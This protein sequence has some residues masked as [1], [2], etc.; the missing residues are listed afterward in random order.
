MMREARDARHARHARHACLGDRNERGSNITARPDSEHTNGGQAS[1]LVR[2]RPQ[3]L[4]WARG[5]TFRIHESS[6]SGTA[7]SW[8]RPILAALSHI[9][10]LVA[11]LGKGVFGKSG[12]PSYKRRSLLS[13][14]RLEVRGRTGQP[15][16]VALQ[17][18]YLMS[19]LGY[20]KTGLESGSKPLMWH[21]AMSPSWISTAPGVPVEI[22]SPGKRVI[23][24]EWNETSHQGE[25]VMLETVLLCSTSPFNTVATSR[26]STSAISSG[27]TS[28]G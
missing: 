8:L 4:D 19:P 16:E 5:P 23:I 6:T 17:V 26:D 10:A 12:V 28:S 11:Y 7:C 24:F 1:L 15:R 22:T 9:W 2:Y 20:R 27:V 3:L 13:H 25:N 14:A 21:S 18:S